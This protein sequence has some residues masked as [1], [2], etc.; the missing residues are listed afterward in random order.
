MIKNFKII[1][2][3]EDLKDEDCIIYHTEIDIK[4]KQYIS[5]AKEIDNNGK[6]YKKGW[7]V[8]TTISNN[9]EVQGM[10]LYYV[11]NAGLTSIELLLKGDSLRKSVIEH[12][13]NECE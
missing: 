10:E 7:L 1:G 6:Y 4:D 2:T 8:I 9:N 13:I 5:Q 11:G 12:I 3:T